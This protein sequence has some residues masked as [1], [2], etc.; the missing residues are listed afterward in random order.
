MGLGVRKIRR[1]VGRRL[2]G[3]GW[4]GG[5]GEVGEGDGCLE[6]R[7]RDGGDAGDIRH[8]VLAG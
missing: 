7:E 8:V 4:C 1:V 3:D 5:R 6:A 2:L